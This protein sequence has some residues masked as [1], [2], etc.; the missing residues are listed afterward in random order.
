ME[1]L[2]EVTKGEILDP[3]NSSYSIGFDWCKAN[4]TKEHS[5]GV[6][7][8]RCDD[9]PVDVPNRD[10]FVMPLM[11]IPGPKEPSNLNPYFN[12]IGREFNSINRKG[13]RVKYRDESGQMKKI[14]HKAFWCFI[15]CDAV[16]RTKFGCFNGAIAQFCCPFCRLPSSN[17][18]GEGGN[19]FKKPLGYDIPV[20][21]E[22]SFPLLDNEKNGPVSYQ[23]GVE[24]E[25]RKLSNE[26][27]KRR[28]DIL[29]EAANNSRKYKDLQKQLGCNGVCEVF[30]IVPTLHRVNSYVLPFYHLIFL[31]VIKS[32][33]SALVTDK[34]KKKKRGTKGRKRKREEDMGELSVS[35]NCNGQEDNSKDYRIKNIN[36]LKALNKSIVLSND[37]GR[38]FRCLSTIKAFL[39]EDMKNLWAYQASLL[40]NKDLCEELKIDILNDGARKAWGLLR[41][42]ISYY[43]DD[44]IS[45][46]DKEQAEDAQKALLEFA[47][48]CEQVRSLLLFSSYE[49]F[50]FDFKIPFCR[51]CLP[52]APKTF[53]FYCV[54]SRTRKE[55]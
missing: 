25:K 18:R 44:S 26:D 34:K 10:S 28:S 36:A 42:A 6:V 50:L 17:F 33:F 13:L 49:Y 52:F 45:V 19:V 55:L 29:L 9:L 46:T 39:I 37:F 23:M 54:E 40:L 4:N 32:F 24:D 21:H 3:L 30:D 20:V 38:A 14:R 22:H 47:K 41:R 51:I 48:F 16:A 31:G 8:L 11:I 1:W 27:M 2:S 15:D 53:M 7:S 5:F 12:I 35:E 43:M